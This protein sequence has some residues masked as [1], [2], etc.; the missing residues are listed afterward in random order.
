MQILVSPFVEAPIA[1]DSALLSKFSKLYAPHTYNPKSIFPPHDKK[2]REYSFYL[3]EGLSVGGVS[4]DED[5][6]GGPKGIPAQFVPGTIQW[7]SGKHGGGVGWLTASQVQVAARTEL[8][9]RS[10]QHRHA[11]P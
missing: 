8:T 9:Y 11:H 5:H 7:D 2:P 1:K 4:F 6:L 10:G 3:E